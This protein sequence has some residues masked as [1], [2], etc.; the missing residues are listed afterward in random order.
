MGIEPTWTCA[1]EIL[2][3]LPIPIRLP[4]HYYFTTGD[5]YQISSPRH[6]AATNTI[7]QHLWHQ[8]RANYQLSKGSCSRIH[9]D[10]V[11]LGDTQS[12]LLLS[13]NEIAHALYPVIRCA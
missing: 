12:D 1:R 4:R 5:V 9:K 8:S 7:L 13:M 6:C 10:Q 2:S 11:S 3:L